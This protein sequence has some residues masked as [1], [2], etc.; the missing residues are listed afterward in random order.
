MHKSAPFFDQRF[1][2]VQQP[3]K[4]LVC[5]HFSCLAECILGWLV[6]SSKIM[7]V[8]QALLMVALHQFKIAFPSDITTLL[9]L[10]SIS[11][12]ITKADD[13]IDLMRIDVSQNAL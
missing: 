11:D 12:K 2:M 13:L 1:R 8:Q 10:W 6:E 5:Q 3:L 7:N 9:R 4:G